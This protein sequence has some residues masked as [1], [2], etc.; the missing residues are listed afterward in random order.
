MMS[1]SSTADRRQAGPTITAF[2]RAEEGSVLVEFA[3]AVPMLLL[4][5]AMIV[6]GSRLMLSYQSVISG[7]RDATRY[8]ARVLPSEI[9]SLG[10][11]PASYSA[12]L[13]DIVGESLSATP[14]LASG[15]RVASVTPAI[16]C[17]TGS[18]RG[19]TIGVAVVSADVVVTFPLGGVFEFFGG[20]DA[21]LTTTVTD[22]SRVFGA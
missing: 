3:L 1:S 7:V 6:E 18:Y 20:S 8:L 12:R 22:R 4:V 10:G 2:R 17:H 14:V 13:T 16:E 9:C 11:S 15:V 19:G 21:T 5:F